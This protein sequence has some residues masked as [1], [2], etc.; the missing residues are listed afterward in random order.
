MRILV[1]G[2]RAMKHILSLTGALALTTTLAQAGGIDRSGQG[3]GAL[4]EKG[5]YA[6]LSFGHVNP[7]VS[8]NDVVGF[9]GGATGNVAASYNQVGLAFKMD[10]NDH[11]SG[12]VI[13][14]QP[15]GAD[16]L[17]APTSVA[18]GGTSAVANTNAVTAL[19]RYKLDN[20]FSA[21]GGLRSQT[22]D[23]HIDLRGL[24]YGGF[25]GYSVDLAT[26]TAVG[27]V[28]GIAYEKPEIAL[29]VALT[30]NSKVKHTFDTT[31]TLGVAVI[32]VTPTRVDTPQSINLDFQTGVAQ[33]TLVF[34]QFRWVNWTSFRLDP[35]TFTPLAGGL[36]DLEDTRTLTLGVGRKFNDNWS[37]AFSMTYEDG[38]SPLVSPLAPTNGRIG[39]TLAA[40]YSQDN[41]KVTTGINYTKLG[42]AQAE[43]GTPD[44]ARADFSGNSAL[45]I[46]IKIGYSF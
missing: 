35:A 46:G 8:G 24:A 27:Y 32:G 21:H 37:G 1:T 9:G 3:I 13:M 38:G 31:E 26:D 18:L 7:S 6:E 25:N 36:I 5:T 19:L 29:R 11:F 17:Y 39:A 42:D 45:G 28:V 41:F 10:F 12:A 44:T 40:I 33:D 2:K 14:D 15:F 30:Y 16:V 23:A 4:F 34:G 22:A 43:T 20:G